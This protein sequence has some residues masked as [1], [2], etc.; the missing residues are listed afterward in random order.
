[1]TIGYV[2]ASC[3]RRLEARASAGDIERRYSQV[4]LA[5]LLLA[6][7]YAGLDEKDSAFK[8]L[9]RAYAARI[10]PLYKLRSEVMFA[11]LRTDPRFQAIVSRMQFP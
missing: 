3:N 9:D 2:L 5:P 10:G 8:W 7:V 1:M 11:S 6:A 4:P